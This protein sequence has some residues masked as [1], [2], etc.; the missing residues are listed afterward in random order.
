M[1]GPRKALA[2]LTQRMQSWMDAWAQ[3][4]QDRVEEQSPY[5]PGT[6]HVYL[7]WYVQRTRTRLVCI[8]HPQEQD[9]VPHALLYPGHAGRALHQ[10]VR[11]SKLAFINFNY[12]QL[13]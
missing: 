13:I 7:Q 5:D 1:Q 8:K 11:D 6:Y 10:A 4:V 3:A 12:I 9:T 2:E